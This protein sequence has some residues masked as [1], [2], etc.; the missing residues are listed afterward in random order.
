MY[1]TPDDFSLLAKHVVGGAS[2]TS[3]YLLLGEVNTY[4]GAAARKKPL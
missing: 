1:L 3:N 2:F 4:F